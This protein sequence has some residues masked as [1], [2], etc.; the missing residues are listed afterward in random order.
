MVKPLIN[1]SDKMMMLMMMMMMMMT[2]M[3]MM[4][5]INKSDVVKGSGPER[6]HL[7]Y[8]I[9]ALTAHELP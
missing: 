8:Q 1:K 2:M 4:M 9:R 7:R 6:V 3:M 5:M